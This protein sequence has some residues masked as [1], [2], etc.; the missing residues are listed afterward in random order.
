MKKFNSIPVKLGLAIIML[1]LVIL[2]PLGYV[3]DN[4]LRN[5]FFS[6]TYQELTIQGERIVDLITN[7]NDIDASK[8]IVNTMKIT[9]H[10]LFLLDSSGEIVVQSNAELNINEVL[11]T[12]DWLVLRSGSSINKQITSTN[13]NYL[14]V[15]EPVI[16]NSIYSGSVLILSSTEEI[17]R[18]ISQVKNFI[19]L[20]GLGAIFLALGFTIVV[21]RKFSLPL[22]EME[23]ATRLIAKGDLTVKVKPKTNDELGSLAVAINDLVSDLKRYQDTRS[24]FFSNISHELRTPLT[25]IEGYLQL[26]KED[27]FQDIEQKNRY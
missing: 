13:P 14:L 9:D 5:Y 24:E 21:V 12:N 4:V 25:Y 27:T 1:I 15:G 6:R 10:S 2:F 22:L 11:F 19:W 8:M 3:L 20:T 26:M 16:Y 23:Q 7:N 17:N 18:S